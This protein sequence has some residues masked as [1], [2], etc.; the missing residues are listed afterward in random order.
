MFFYGLVMVDCVK[1]SSTC[2]R[3]VSEGN[4]NDR[5]IYREVRKLFLCFFPHISMAWET[6]FSIN[7]QT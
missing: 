6:L 2:G 7:K 3:I 1:L 5:K 4:F